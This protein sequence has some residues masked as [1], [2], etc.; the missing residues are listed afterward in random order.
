MDEKLNLF[1]GTVT[2][3]LAAIGAFLGWKGIL[4]LVWAVLMAIDYISGSAA[5]AKEGNWSSAAARQGIWHKAGM[6]LVVIV[7]ALADGVLDLAFGNLHIGFQWPGILLPLVLVWYIITEMGSILENA[8][9][10]GAKLPSWLPKI[11]KAGLK[12]VDSVG[13]Q[14]AMEERKDE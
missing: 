8:V 6:I 12:A 7:A 3:V 10:M 9:K 2:A 14:A 5:A 4:A 1:K 13:D 11:M